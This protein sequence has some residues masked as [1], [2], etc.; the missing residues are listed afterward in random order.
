[1]KKGIEILPRIL[2]V[3]RQ[4][5]LGGTERRLTDLAKDLTKKKYIVEI[6][7]TV[8]DK[9]TNQ[10]KDKLIRTPVGRIFYIALKIIQFKPDIVH[11]FDI[12]TGI[13]VYLAKIFSFKRFKL[14]SGYGAGIIQVKSTQFLLRKG[15][16]LADLYVCNSLKAI[17][18]LKHYLHS[19]V[20][21]VLVRNG[22]DNK[23]LDGN[24]PIEVEL[25]NKAFNRKI[26]GYIGKF[27]E[28]KHAER[29]FDLAEYY[30]RKYAANDL[31]FVIIGEGPFRQ[32]ILN[33]LSR[34]TENLQNSIFIPGEIKD[35]G[36]LAKHFKVGL[37]CSDT[38]GFP[39]VLIEFMYFGV[40][41]ISTDVG[42]V[43]FIIEKGHAGEVINNWDLELFS[44]HLNLML[45][46]EEVRLKMANEGQRIFN[47]EF[48]VERMSN[49]FID[50]YK[51]L[52]KC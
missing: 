19:E 41:W 21:I 52:I 27:N 38:E 42:D 3:S 43:K 37:L 11:S 14:V 15:W 5:G 16:F 10:F 1:V 39:N 40:P 45:N 33:R 36:I 26:I 18:S 50:L 4:Q 51:N 31:F 22:L 8:N 28:E 25:L 9:R 23:R 30:I 34:S 20:K 44:Y 32:D 35:A 2:L 6:F 29:I 13:Y 7:F 47:E 46:N 24:L 17:Q 12:E 49:E 48:T